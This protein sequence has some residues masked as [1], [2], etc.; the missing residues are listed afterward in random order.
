M[1]QGDFRSIAALA[2]VIDA[3]SFTDAAH[4]LHMT[5]S[6]VSQRI[7]LLEGQVGGPVIVRSNPPQLT[8]LGETLVRHWRQVSSLESSL[9]KELHNSTLPTRQ[10]IAIGLNSD[11]LATWF[12]SAI[13]PVVSAHELL[14]QLVVDYEEQTLALLRSGKVIACVSVEPQPI[15]GCR[16]IPLGEMRYRCCATPGFRKRYFPD[17]VTKEAMLQAPAALFGRGDT[18][19]YRYFER[20]FRVDSARFPHHIVPSTEGFLQVA[21]AGIAHAMLPEV[22]VAPYLRRRELVDL[23]PGKFIGVKLYWHMWDLRTPLTEALTDVLERSCKKFLVT[24]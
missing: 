13:A 15:S 17:G 5:Q 14:V 9:L 6:A 1:F 12:F 23:T 18:I 3:Q 7:R 21:L 2:A 11:S 4:D 24:G 22:Q 16:V 20:H 19:I 8:P 10:S